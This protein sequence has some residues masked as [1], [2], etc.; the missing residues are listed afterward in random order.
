M[1]IT[2]KVR[3]LWKLGER[4]CP[5]VMKRLRRFQKT[6]DSREESRT[7]ASLHATMPIRNFSQHLLENIVNKLAIIELK[8]VVWS[9]WGQPKRIGD[10]LCSLNMEPS[11]QKSLLAS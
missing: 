8:N 10:T 1:I 11:F 5:D 3:T 7:L 4:W 9:D 6:I 2:A